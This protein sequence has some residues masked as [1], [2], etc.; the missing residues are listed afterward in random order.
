MLFFFIVRH[1]I[2]LYSFLFFFLSIYKS[3]SSRLSFV[4]VILFFCFVLKHMKKCVFK[5]KSHVLL[6]HF[7]LVP[8]FLKRVLNSDRGVS[9]IE[10][11][12]K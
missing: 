3:T 5:Q 8:C 1:L 9:V 11:C 2:S 7:S 4:F 6:F 10:T 12:A